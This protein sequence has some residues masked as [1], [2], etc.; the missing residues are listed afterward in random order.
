MHFDFVYGIHRDRL[1]KSDSGSK[2]KACGIQ[3]RAASPKWR[4]KR[5]F[6]VRAD[7][8]ERSESE[9]KLKVCERGWFFSCVQL[10][11]VH[12][13]EVHLI[14]TSVC[15]VQ[16]NNTALLQ[17]KMSKTSGIFCHDLSKRFMGDVIR[18]P[19]VVIRHREFAKRDAA[20]DFEPSSLPERLSCHNPLLLFICFLIYI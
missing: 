16:D 13:I 1:G 12:E 4:A 18:H 19:S 10:N 11:A 6:E 8:S 15:L 5:S 20:K 17:F 3:A 2:P 14:S 9:S 7:S